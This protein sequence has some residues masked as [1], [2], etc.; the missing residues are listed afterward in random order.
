MT[1]FKTT[2]LA[3]TALTLL[4]GAAMADGNK[5]YIHQGGAGGGKNEAS[6]TQQGT[7]NNQAG[8]ADEPGGAIDQ[9]AD[10]GWGEANQL[11]IS[12]DGGNLKVGVTGALVSD[13]SGFQGA[14]VDQYGWKNSADVTQTG[15]GN[16][17]GSVIQR[18]YNANVTGNKLE[19]TQSN[20]GNNIDYAGQNYVS[21]NGVTAA[22]TATLTF[23]G[24]NNGTQGVAE[25]GAGYYAGGPAGSSTWGVNAMVNV[26]GE[27]NANGVWQ[28][29]AG[30]Q[31]GMTVTGDDTRFA[32]RQD[33]QQ[34]RANNLTIAGTSN[35]LSIRQKGQGNSAMVASIGAGSNGNSIGILQNQKDNTALVGVIGS[36]NYIGSRQD[37]EGNNTNASVFGNGNA[38]YAT[39]S[40]NGN[41]S[42]SVIFGNANYLN[43]TQTGNGN[44][45]NAFVV[46]DRNNQVDTFNSPRITGQM[47]V[48]NARVGTG[49][50]TQTGDGNTVL[51]SVNSSDNRFATY[52]SGN[53][54]N[55]RGTIGSVGG[56]N[57]AFVAQ[58]GNSNLTSF[59][60]NG[61]GNVLAV[62]QK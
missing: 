26:A 32:I 53:G 14:G 12:Q 41:F 56:G 19:I 44:I 18:N 35:A 37:G 42:Q 7:G 24:K 43:N 10:H 30:N 52:Q 15:S 2:L 22:N 59:T 47:T 17:V 4:T 51:L 20:T 29:G 11:T 49:E 9:G 60:Q 23:S 57:Q 48:A 1:V 55:I 36:D 6:I 38:T 50:L 3:A 61:A 62:V 31:I 54:N 39:Q 21:G 16:T 58:V 40:G 28:V 34:N 8:K 33:G 27:P 25:G 45:S 13:G 46:G 5:A